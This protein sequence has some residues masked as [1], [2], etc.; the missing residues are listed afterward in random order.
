M[1]TNHIFIANTLAHNYHSIIFNKGVN[2]AIV[3]LTGQ[4]EVTKIVCSECL[5]RPVVFVFCAV[6]CVCFL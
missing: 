5:L 2:A 4:R 1:P 3:L 6:L